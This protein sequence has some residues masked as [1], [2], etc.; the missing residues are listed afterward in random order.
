[1][2]EKKRT[3]QNDLSKHDVNKDSCFQIS[4]IPLQKEKETQGIK[5]SVGK[6]TCK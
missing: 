6:R 4:S 5:C 3:S 1:M 2:F